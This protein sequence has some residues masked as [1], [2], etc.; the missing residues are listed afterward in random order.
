MTHVAV[1]ARSGVGR[2]TV[3][4]R[5]PDTSGMLRDAIVQRTR[6]ARITPTGGLRAGLVAGLD[7]LRRVLHGP[8]GGH[9]R[10]AVI[11]RAG[12][13]PVFAEL[14]RELY[15]AGSRVRRESGRGRSA[16]CRP[17]STWTWR[18]TGWRARRSTGGLRAGGGFGTD[19]V[20]AVVGGFLAA[21]AQGA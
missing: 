8:V 11:A 5:W 17:A 20:R 12:V 15:A 21:A 13:D 16:S 3:H 9:G 18:S 10:R 19:V 6:A 7:A 4:R 14:E 1:A 2:A